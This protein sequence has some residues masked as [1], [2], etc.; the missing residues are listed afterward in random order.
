MRFT[1]IVFGLLVGG[2]T[3]TAVSAAGQAIGDT[4]TL[5]GCL[6]Q[7]QEGEHM[8]FTLE[9]V[10]DAGVEGRPIELLPGETVSLVGHVGHMVE[11]T[12]IV[13]SDGDDDEG[14]N[15]GEDEDEDEDDGELHIRVG[16][17]GHR[18]ASCSLD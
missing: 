12:G 2:V 8:E 5:V 4:V 1:F 14:E 13:V 9:N 10:S 15:E 11:I 7:S 16:S 3:V 18:A 6:A 17:M